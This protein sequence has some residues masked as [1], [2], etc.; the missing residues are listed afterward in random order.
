MKRM[1]LIGCKGI[2][3]LSEKPFL[4]NVLCIALIICSPLWADVL[5][6]FVADFMVFCAKVLGECDDE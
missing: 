5:M 3:K 6:G 4:V 2:T 1:C